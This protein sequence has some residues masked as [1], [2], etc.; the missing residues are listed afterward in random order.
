MN[1]LFHLQ[2]SLYTKLRE[3]FS[4]TIKSPCLQIRASKYRPKCFKRSNPWA[5]P[6]KKFL[7]KFT[8]CL[9]KNAVVLVWL[10]TCLTSHFCPE[11]GRINIP[12]SQLCHLSSFLLKWSCARSL[13][14]AIPHDGPN[15]WLDKVSLTT[16]VSHPTG[17]FTTSC[18]AHPS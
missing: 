15:I 13:L 8:Q 16:P 4:T 6:I 1:Q 10:D 2:V 9:S 18:Y 11:I 7:S 3:K 12:S 17:T 14:P 5:N